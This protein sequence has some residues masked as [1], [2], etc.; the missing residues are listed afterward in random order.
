MRCS[1]VVFFS[2]LVVLLC[3]KQIKRENGSMLDSETD[4]YAVMRKRMVEEQ[5]VKRGVKDN[6]VLKAMLHVPRHHY[7]PESLHEYAYGDEPLSIGFNQTI[8]QPYI[9]AYMTESLQ[10]HGDEKVLEIGTG[11]GYQAAVLAEIVKEVYTIEIIESL[12][13]QAEHLLA[14]EGYRNV[15]CRCGDGYRG[16]PEAAPFD[17]IMVTAAPNIIP[18]PLVDQLADDGR[19][20]LPVGEWSQELVLLVKKEGHLHKRSLLPVRFVPM[21]G[22]VEKSSP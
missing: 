16:W 19:M 20:I 2:G 18:Q 17:A 4:S 8:S 15:R 21:T 10:L 22:D 14:K 9:V 7:V 3:C 5:I 11:S 1:D 13:I 12:A 6:L